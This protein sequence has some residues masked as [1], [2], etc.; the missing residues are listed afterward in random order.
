MLVGLAVI[1][2]DMEGEESRPDEVQRRDGIAADI[3]V[4][5]VE[6]VANAV[7]TDALDE[8]DDLGDGITEARLRRQGVLD[9]DRQAELAAK[10][11]E[12]CDAVLTGDELQRALGLI[13]EQTAAMGDQYP[14]AELRKGSGDPLRLGESL[15]ASLLVKS[16]HGDYQGVGNVQRAGFDAA[17]TQRGP[18]TLKS[19]AVGIGEMLRDTPDF[20][21]ADALCGQERQVWQ[22]V[23]FVVPEERRDTEFHC[24]LSDMQRHAVMR[25]ENLMLGKDACEFVGG[26]IDP[27]VRVHDVLGDEMGAGLEQTL[28][29]ETVLHLQ[30]RLGAEMPVTTFLQLVA[31]AIQSDDIETVARD[32]GPCLVREPAGVTC[33]EQRPA[34]VLEDVDEGL[35]AGGGIVVGG[36]GGENEVIVRRGESVAGVEDVHLQVQPLHIEKAVELLVDRQQLGDAAVAVEVQRLTIHAT[37]SGEDAGVEMILVRVGDEEMAHLGE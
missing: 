14:P 18:Q 30:K 31:S 3:S 33:V 37:G 13:G 10:G 4:T 23:G 29:G 34:G 16:G 6:T 24:Y 35:F 12:L 5:C 1:V 21:M 8:S 26:G 27:I 36:E 32:A 22:Q 25:D 28:G 19:S 17:I 9:S 7:G 2:A 11:G 15:G 20:D